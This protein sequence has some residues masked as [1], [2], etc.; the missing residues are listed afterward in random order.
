MWL[1]CCCSWYRKRE[2]RK[3]LNGFFLFLKPIYSIKRAKRVFSPSCV[4]LY[5]SFFVIP[6]GST[7]RQFRDGVQLAIVELLPRETLLLRLVRIQL[8]E[9]FTIKKLSFSFSCA[10][11]N[12]FQKY[13]RVVEKRHR[14]SW[15]CVF[16]ARHPSLDPQKRREFYFFF[17]AACYF[18]F[19]QIRKFS[20]ETNR[21]CFLLRQ[22]KNSRHFPLLF[23]R[24]VLFI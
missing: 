8:R 1:C 10:I 20:C 5:V 19:S 21:A 3:K 15:F 24:F 11:F 13:T 23:Y 7:P 4:F 12:G 14:K 17:I 16:I 18:F 9:W 22:Q 6:R 2:R